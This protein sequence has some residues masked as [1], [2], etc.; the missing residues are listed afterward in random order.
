MLFDSLLFSSIYA[1]ASFPICNWSNAKFKVDLKNLKNMKADLKTKKAP[2]ELFSET[3]P[4]FRRLV[5]D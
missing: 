5:L 3:F 1:R 2:V 4:N